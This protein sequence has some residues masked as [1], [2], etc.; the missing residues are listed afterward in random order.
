MVLCREF[1]F[2]CSSDSSEVPVDESTSEAEGNE[3]GEPAKW[4]KAFSM[5]T[6]QHI[7]FEPQELS[8]SCLISRG[9][10]IFAAVQKDILELEFCSTDQ[11]TA[12]TESRLET[13]ICQGLGG[14][15]HESI[16]LAEHTLT[17]N[18]K[19]NSFI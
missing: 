8:V 9:G 7:E 4:S 1:L 19:P 17:V 5:A 2:C 3:A 14:R 13:A 12:R 11:P 15:Q 16:S 18:T 6:F 10:T